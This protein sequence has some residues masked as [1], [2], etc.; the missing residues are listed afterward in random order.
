MI[1]LETIVSDFAKE[2]NVE[3]NSF[4]LSRI[5][6]I[7]RKIRGMSSEDIIKALSLEYKFR[8]GFNHN[9][10]KKLEEIIKRALR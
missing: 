10:W 2:K 9:D 1:N 7:Q 3:I 4:M 5:R 6:S 8:V